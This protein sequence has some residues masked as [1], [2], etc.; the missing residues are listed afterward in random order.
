MFYWGVY[1]LEAMISRFLEKI[2]IKKVLD[3]RGQ[4]F[5]RLKKVLVFLIKTSFF[6]DSDTKEYPRLSNG[7]NGGRRLINGLAIMLTHRCNVGCAYCLRSVDKTRESPEINFDTLRRIILSAH[8]FGCRACGITGGE[9]FLHPRL[10]EVI[11][12]LGDL[13]WLVGIETNGKVLNPDVCD[14]LKQKLGNKLLISVSLDSFRK[15]SHDFFRGE[16]SFDS[17]VRA[18]KLIMAYDIRVETNAI[19]TPQNF[20]TE[21]DLLEFMD[22]NR[23]LKVDLVRM[24]RVIPSG[25]GSDGKFLLSQNQIFEFGDILEKYNFQNPSLDGSP[26]QSYKSFENR[27]NGWCPKGM[28][29]F[30]ISPAGV[31]HCIFLE[32]IK[33]GEFNDFENII[34]NE[35]LKN[36]MSFIQEAIFEYYFER[37]AP[38]S[39]AECV[40]GF[41]KLS[42]ILRD[43]IKCLR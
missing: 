11:I 24:G 42:N 27:N 18:I 30:C 20:M 33:S 22:F 17:A 23:G 3:C 2:I 7:C 25:R 10:R 39:C 8:R 5:K 38:F 14:F 34:A 35:R 16:G 26:F 43:V 41:S 28:R 13:N 37:K 12:L 4:D 9:P 32:N 15:K 31:H 29:Q 21:K 1:I 6:F 36:F 19:L 40:C